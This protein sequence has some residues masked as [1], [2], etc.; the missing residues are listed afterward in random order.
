MTLR[1][2]DRALESNEGSIIKVLR[3]MVETTYS[4]IS[5]FFKNTAKNWNSTKS[6]LENSTDNTTEELSLREEKDD[7]SDF[8]PLKLLIFPHDHVMNANNSHEIYDD[9]ITFSGYS[10]FKQNE[11]Y[12]DENGSGDFDEM[13]ET[14]DPL[15]NLYFVPTSNS[16]QDYFSGD[17]IFTIQNPSTSSP[18]FLKNLTTEGTIFHDSNPIM[19]TATEK[20]E[21]VILGANKTNFPA[22]STEETPIMHNLTTTFSTS[23][24]VIPTTMAPTYSKNKVNMLSSFFNDSSIHFLKTRGNASSEEMFSQ[25]L[26]TP[27]PPSNDTTTT[28]L[29]TSRTI[30]PT[31]FND[32]FTNFNNV[33]DANTIKGI[34]PIFIIIL[35]IAVLVCIIL[36]IR[37][38]YRKSH[39]DTY[40]IA[41]TVS[42][43]GETS[44]HM[45]RLHEGSGDPNVLNQPNQ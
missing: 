42:N 2:D 10:S 15:S 25:I 24:S 4:T 41:S 22:S 14:N 39:R 35:P 18:T 13:A 45:A 36:L 34:E 3:D 33:T 29:Q 44:I 21:E 32:T 5:F 30:E 28:P 23:D 27:L 1:G 40:E 16:S 9:K 26:T 6:E 8:I 17:G 12:T 38:I 7:F 20:I 31:S 43:E 19:K 37:F 11:L